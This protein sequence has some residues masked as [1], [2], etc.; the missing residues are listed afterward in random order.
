MIRPYRRSR[1]N[2]NM[3]QVP[4]IIVFVPFKFHFDLYCIKLKQ[5]KYIEYADIN[6]D[7]DTDVIDKK[8]RDYLKLTY[9]IKELVKETKELRHKKI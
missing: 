1:I 7:P 2:K 8:I 3:S 5:L 6:K 9:Q 4:F